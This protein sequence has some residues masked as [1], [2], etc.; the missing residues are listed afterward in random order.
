MRSMIMGS[1]LRARGREGFLRKLLTAG[2]DVVVVY[3]FCTD[4]YAEMAA[5]TVPSTIADFEVLAEHYSAIRN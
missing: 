3:T 5:R 2:T 1:T 4:M